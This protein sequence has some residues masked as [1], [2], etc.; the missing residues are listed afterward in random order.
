MRKGCTKDLTGFAICETLR[1]SQA[2]FDDTSN[3]ENKQAAGQ[4]V[5]CL[6]A[7]FNELQGGAEAKRARCVLYRTCGELTMK[8]DNFM[9]SRLCRNRTISPKAD[10]RRERR[11]FRVCELSG[12]WRNP[13]N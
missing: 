1:A 11:I 5:R 3:V 8:N 4:V 12:R 13:R 9:T 10:G 2:M 7:I 6:P